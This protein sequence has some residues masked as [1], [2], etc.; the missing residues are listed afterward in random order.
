VR[1]GGK[2]PVDDTAQQGQAECQTAFALLTRK[3]IA[4]TPV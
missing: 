4:D 2:Q 3:M 1:E